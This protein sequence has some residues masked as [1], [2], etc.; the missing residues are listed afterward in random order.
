MLTAKATLKS[1]KFSGTDR[2]STRDLSASVATTLLAPLSPAS[3]HESTMY[4]ASDKL[5]EDYLPNAI[6]ARSAN[7]DC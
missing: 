2:A 5:E 4:V 1:L 3:R 6:L 7:S